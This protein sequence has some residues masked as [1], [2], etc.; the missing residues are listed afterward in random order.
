[1]VPRQDLLIWLA[2]LRDELAQAERES[3]AA[4]AK[5]QK[6]A[7]Q[8]AL[9]GELLGEVVS[10]QPTFRDEL[11]EVLRNAGAPLHLERL[12]QELTARHVEVPGRGAD[13]NIIAHLRR[14][15]EV[16]RVA[17]GTYALRAEHDTPTAPAA[18]TKRRRKRRKP[19]Q[20]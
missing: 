14:I 7:R 9:V 20:P 1:M 19:A 13:A 15:P 16:K 8:I 4:E 5:R 17:K 6:T 18:P 11:V 2:T 3:A 12:R 10:T